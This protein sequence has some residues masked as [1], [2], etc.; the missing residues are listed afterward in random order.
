MRSEQVVSP[1]KL[2]PTSILK[3]AWGLTVALGKPTAA[4]LRAIR[5]RIA[6]IQCAVA[7]AERKFEADLSGQDGLL[8]LWS[9]PGRSGKRSVGVSSRSR[10]REQIAR[11]DEAMTVLTIDATAVNSV[12]GQ[13]DQS[14]AVVMDV[15]SECAEPCLKP[16]FD[17]IMV[18]SSHE[19]GE[20]S[21][22]PIR[23]IRCWTSVHAYFRGRSKGG[24]HCWY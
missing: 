3:K 24:D 5:G 1:F 11:R 19:E 17:P 2:L 22:R 4:E 12:A 16:G 6:R 10:Y 23:I 8:A 7:M 13:A 18:R 14:G 9:M 21:H 20:K 15:T